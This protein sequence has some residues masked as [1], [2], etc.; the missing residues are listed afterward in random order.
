MW[1]ALILLGGYSLGLAVPFVLAAVAT[2]SFLDTSKRLR[3]AIP[4]LEKV[5]GGVLI[6]VGLLLVTG[7]FTMLS[8][9]FVRFTPDF[10]LRRI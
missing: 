10:I 2:G 3:R 6:V 7:S 8:S 1:G 5:S 4:V 9:Y